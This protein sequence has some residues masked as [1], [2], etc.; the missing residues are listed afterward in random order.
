MTTTIRSAM[1]LGATLVTFAGC[2]APADMK[3]AQDPNT[4]GA[5]G[6]TVVIGSNSTIA[7]DALATYYQQKWGSYGRNR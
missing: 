7:G 3:A 1:L 4:P 2:A 5:T 6:R